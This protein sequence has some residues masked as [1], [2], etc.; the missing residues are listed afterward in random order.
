MNNSRFTTTSIIPYILIGASTIS[1]NSSA[2]MP[3]TDF[4]STNI[5][6]MT[7]TRYAQQ[8]QL[9]SEN[10]KI[11]DEYVDKQYHI[12]LASTYSSADYP[13]LELVQS[14]SE[15]QISLEPEFSSALD[16]LLLVN[17]NNKPSKQRF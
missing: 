11:M 10:F 7:E 12:E 14:L 15:N 17:I 8:P 1:Y 16:E 9:L 4:N 2:T 13:F 6:F 5:V 3:E